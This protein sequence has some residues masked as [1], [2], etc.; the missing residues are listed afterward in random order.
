MQKRRFSEPA[1]LT[2]DCRSD[3]TTRR[4]SVH[5]VRTPVQRLRS[6]HE[7]SHTRTLPLRHR[8]RASL[9]NVYARYTN[10]PY[11]SMPAHVRYFEPR[12]LL[13]VCWMRKCR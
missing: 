11:S 13:P 8:L 10:L 6:L 1:R 12:E 3:Y 2:L 9:C 4:A 5:T 7:P